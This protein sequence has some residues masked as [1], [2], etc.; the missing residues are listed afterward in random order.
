MILPL[1][2]IAVFFALYL[3]LV[4]GL[5]WKLILGVGGVFGIYMYLEVNVPSSAAQVFQ[6]SSLAW[7]HWSLAIPSV[8]LMLALATTKE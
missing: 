3:L 1:V 8:I 6:D 2:G 7:I 5:L 4:K